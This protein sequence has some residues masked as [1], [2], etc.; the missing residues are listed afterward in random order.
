MSQRV[1]EL[2][3]TMKDV[4]RNIRTAVLCQPNVTLSIKVGQEQLD[5]VGLIPD[6]I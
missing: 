1:E 5:N 6:V 3:A 2:L 4:L